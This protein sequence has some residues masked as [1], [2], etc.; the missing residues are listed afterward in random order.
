M[1]NDDTGQKGVT[2]KEF[3]GISEKIVDDFPKQEKTG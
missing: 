3:T 2:A 1:K